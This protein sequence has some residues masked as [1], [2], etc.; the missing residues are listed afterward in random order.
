MTRANDQNLQLFLPLSI[1]LHCVP[2]FLSH[3]LFL[4]LSQLTGFSFRMN[5][6]LYSS[7]PRDPIPSANSLQ[8]TIRWQEVNVN[9]NIFLLYIEINT[10][11]FLFLLFSYFSFLFFL[12]ILS[13]F[14]S[15]C[16]AFLHFFILFTQFVGKIV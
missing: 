5:Q 9:Y 6:V 3:C 8:L 11:F 16:H 4:P 1:T 14:Q 12:S 13:Q 7:P 2:L 15:F 10:F